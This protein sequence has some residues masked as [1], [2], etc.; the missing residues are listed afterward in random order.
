MLLYLT[1]ELAQA[2]SIKDGGE[3]TGVNS[4]VGMKECQVQLAGQQ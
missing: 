1:R 4:E 3:V 2:L